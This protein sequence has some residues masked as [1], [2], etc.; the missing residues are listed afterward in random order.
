V[1]DKHGVVT[2]EGKGKTI[3]YNGGKEAEVV[4]LLAV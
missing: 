1:R 2:V 3:R 4:F